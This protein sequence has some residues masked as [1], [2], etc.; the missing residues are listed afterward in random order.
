MRRAFVLPS[1]ADVASL[2]VHASLLQS[3]IT[4]LE[5]DMLRLRNTFTLLDTKNH[6]TRSMI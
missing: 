4:S 3:Q 1:K 2:L 6:R 5:K